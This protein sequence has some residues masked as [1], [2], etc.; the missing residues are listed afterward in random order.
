MHFWSNFLHKEYLGLLNMCNWKL[1]EYLLKFASLKNL[2]I[3]S[4]EMGIYLNFYWTKGWLSTN[5]QNMLLLCPIMSMVTIS[6]YFIFFLA[7]T[8]TKNTNKF[9]FFIWKM[10]KCRGYL[11]KFIHDWKYY[12]RSR[13]IPCA[14]HRHNNYLHVLNMHAFYI[15]HFWLWLF[16]SCLCVISMCITL[17]NYCSCCNSDFCTIYIFFKC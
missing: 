10:V 3:R 11:A 8:K 9:S 14:L 16:I 15:W 1:F 6:L 12:I 17:H 7:V 2:V 4:S 13:L 5:F